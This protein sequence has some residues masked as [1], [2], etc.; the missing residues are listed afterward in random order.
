VVAQ[1]NLAVFPLGAYYGTVPERA[2]D[3]SI[4]ELQLQTAISDGRNGKL[5]RIVWLPPITIAEERQEI[6]AKTHGWLLRA[7]GRMRGRA[8]QGK[9]AMLKGGT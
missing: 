8:A 6:A 4:T 3:R 7:L 5:S 1:C 9:G 2:G